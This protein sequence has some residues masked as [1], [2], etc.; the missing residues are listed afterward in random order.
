MNPISTSI[1]GMFA[2][3]STRKGAC[4]IGHGLNGT[5]RPSASLTN[6]ARSA[7]GA[8]WRAWA[9]SHGIMSILADP[10]ARHRQVAAVPVGEFAGLLAVLVD[11]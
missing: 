5:R 8:R 3:T 6:P 10:A 4:R 1:A 2:P 7:D 11:C 9:I